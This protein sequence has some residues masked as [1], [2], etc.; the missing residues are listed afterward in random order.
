MASDGYL[1]SVLPGD[2]DHRAVLV[3]PSLETRPVRLR[4]IRRPSLMTVP[5]GGERQ[6]AVVTRPLELVAKLEPDQRDFVKIGK[7]QQILQSR[8]R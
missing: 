8:R 1:A 3:E 7:G 5:A 4:P 2:V 6:I